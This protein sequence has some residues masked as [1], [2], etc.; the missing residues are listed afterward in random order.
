M[1]ELATRITDP[2][3][4]ATAFVRGVEHPK[5]REALDKPLDP[6]KRPDEVIIPITELLGSN[7]H[8]H[9]TGWQLEP[10]DGSM[11]DRA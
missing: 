7:G 3:A 9:C 4:F 10:V 8:E 5:V 6:G 1:R 11:D 2:D